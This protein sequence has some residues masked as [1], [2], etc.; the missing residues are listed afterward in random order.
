M[1]R[2]MSPTTR[3]KVDVLL[4]SL[5]ILLAVEGSV[6]A[7][8]LVG[9]SASGNRWLEVGDTVIGVQVAGATEVAMPII[10]GNTTVLLAFRS[11][12]PYGGDVA[13][14]WYRWIQENAGRRVIAVTSEPR[15]AGEGYL[16]QLGLEVELTT[17]D[18]RSRPTQAN[19]LVARVPWVFVLDADGVILAHGHGALIEEVGGQPWDGATLGQP[20]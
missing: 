1:E 4:L 17:I 20:Q 8:R 12:C 16:A 3:G 7:A 15:Q 2:G 11:D 19:L 18:D 9:P 6:L 10:G 14:I 5:A 13:P